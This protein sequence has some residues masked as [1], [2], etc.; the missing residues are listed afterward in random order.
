MADRLPTVSINQAV[1]ST[2]NRNDS[3]AIRDSA[4]HSRMTP[5]SP[6][7]R[8][9]ATRLRARSFIELNPPFG[10]SE[11]THAVMNS[12]RAQPCLG[13][14][15]SGPLLGDQIRC[16]YPH[17][18]EED[19]GVP[20]VVAIVVTKHR[21]RRTTVT[22]GVSRGTRI[23]LCW[24]CFCASGSVFPMTMK[25]FASGSIAPVAHHLRPEMT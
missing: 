11:Q 21:Q 9:N 3:M 2:S 22:P 8:P 17:M 10:H 15:E 16:G 1:L 14:C 25:I 13:N 6:S 24:R 20:T 19:L 12:S 18:V 7:D 4:T 5:W 23:M